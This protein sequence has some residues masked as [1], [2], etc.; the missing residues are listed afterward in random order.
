MVL[1]QP[2]PLPVGKDRN[3]NR[4]N[5]VHWNSCIS[6]LC[7]IPNY[8]RQPWHH[9]F[10]SSSRQSSQV[11]FHWN[12]DE[13]RGFPLI[14]LRCWETN[15]TPIT[16]IRQPTSILKKRAPGCLVWTKPY[17]PLEVTRMRSVNPSFEKSSQIRACVGGDGR[18]TVVSKLPPGD[19][20]TA[21]WSPAARTNCWLSWARKEKDFSVGTTVPASIIPEG[22]GRFDQEAPVRS[23]HCQTAS[24][25]CKPGVYDVTW[26]RSVQSWAANSSGKRKEQKR[27]KPPT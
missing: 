3:P 27:T 9:D 11:K 12:P 25:P 7:R 8:N 13:P 16:I 4:A 26:K 20:N 22:D 10:T 2:R 23:C 18:M 1:P 17:T 6:Q 21:S 19:S 15:S 14:E 5:N 24:W